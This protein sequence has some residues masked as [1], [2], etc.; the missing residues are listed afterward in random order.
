MKDVIPLL[1]GSKVEDLRRAFVAAQIRVGIH[2]VLGGG[3]GRIP[4]REAQIH[5]VV[6]ACGFVVD[7]GVDV[8][9]PA[10][11]DHGRVFD[12]RALMARI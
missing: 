9:I 8:P 4:V 10:G 11:I 2:V 5:H 1:V 6:G 7:G 3:I 12:R